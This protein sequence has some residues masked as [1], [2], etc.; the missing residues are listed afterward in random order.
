MNA[1]GK[2]INNQLEYMKSNKNNIIKVVKNNKKAPNKPEMNNITTNKETQNWRQRH[3]ITTPVHKSKK[4]EEK[5]KDN[6]KK[7]EIKKI[8]FKSDEKNND[9]KKEQNAKVVEEDKN[10]ATPNKLI[11]KPKHIKFKGILEESPEK[12]KQKKK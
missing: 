5:N 8:I 12:E 3:I 7:E 9:V 11:K 2:T 4:D 10:K 6:I 1:K